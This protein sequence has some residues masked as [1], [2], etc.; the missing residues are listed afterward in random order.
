MRSTHRRLYPAID[1]PLRRLF[2]SSV[3]GAFSHGRLGTL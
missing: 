2:L 1:T 3:M